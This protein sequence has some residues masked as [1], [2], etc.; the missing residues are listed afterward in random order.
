M[1]PIFILILVVFSFSLKAGEL[2]F[3]TPQSVDVADIPA[4][5]AFDSEADQQ[6]LEIVLKW[7]NNRTP[8]ECLR[9]TVEA[10]GYATSFFGQP[11]GP[12][13][14][15]EA[16]RLVNFQQILFNE[17]SFFAR[18]LKI[19]H[20]RVRPFLRDA[21]VSPCIPTHH[22][23]SY[24]SGHATIAYVAAR[25]FALIYPE[26]RHAFYQRAFEIAQG[27]VIGGVH[28]P[29]DVEAGELLGGKIFQALKASSQFMQEVR[30]L[31]K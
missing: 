9:A 22:S 13:N 11:Y 24:P 16:R 31:K 8:M 21:R 7:Q 15:E 28:Y 30:S 4:P 26:Q 29:S 25:T 12:L 1:K 14:Q 6:D 5:P 18:Q 23:N 17:I 2:R 19:S 3:L 27:R 10:E 20:Q